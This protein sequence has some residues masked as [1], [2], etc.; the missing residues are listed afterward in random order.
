MLRNF[1]M[2]L[3]KNDSRTRFYFWSFSNPLS[4]KFLCI[5]SF[6]KI[7]LQKIQRTKKEKG[8]DEKRS[9]LRKVGTPCYACQKRQRKG[10]SLCGKHSKWL[11]TLQNLQK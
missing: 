8:S 9:F 4:W 6:K 5:G 10:H 3:A 11:Y 2:S 1:K 7:F